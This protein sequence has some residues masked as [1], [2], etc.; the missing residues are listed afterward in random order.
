MVLHSEADRSVL[1]SRA[2]LGDLD[3]PHPALNAVYLFTLASFKDSILLH[4][5][6]VGKELNIGA[7]AE[8]GAELLGLFP[9]FRERP[10]A[11]CAVSSALKRS[12]IQT[13]GF[14]N[15][16]GWFQILIN[17]MNE[18][19][20]RGLRTA[21]LAVRFGVARRARGGYGRVSIAA[22]QLYGF[23]GA[24]EFAFAAFRRKPEHVK[25]M[26]KAPTIA[27]AH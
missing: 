9:S 4:P 27:S 12:G 25:P 17:H 3:F 7:A 5:T 15:E 11:P 16:V 14:L 10:P 20:E 13:H 19:V 8:I 23:D 18:L 2:V 21:H 1:E 22:H 24:S 6:D 26:S